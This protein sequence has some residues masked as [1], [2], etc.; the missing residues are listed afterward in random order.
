M[1]YPSSENKGADQLCGYCKA[2]L[3]VWF[4]IIMQIVGFPMRWLVCMLAN[5]TYTCAVVMR[6][7]AFEFLSKQ[8]S[9][10]MFSHIFEHSVLEFI[11]KKIIRT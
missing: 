2:D 1:Y 9:S 10:W 7:I 4:C 3:H 11:E 5:Y 6:K 8:I